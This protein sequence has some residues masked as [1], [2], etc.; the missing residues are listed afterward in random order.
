MP[1]GYYVEADGTVRT[2]KSIEKEIEQT[3]K[4]IQFDNAFREKT[5][6]FNK[7]PYIKKKPKKIKTLISC[8]TVTCPRCSKKI[9]FTEINAH[10]DWHREKI[11]KKI[12]Y[13]IK[14]KSQRAS[15]N[16]QEKNLKPNHAP[17]EHLKENSKK[18]Q[19]QYFGQCP[20][21][22]KLLARKLTFKAHL[23]EEKSLIA[24]VKIKY[25]K[26][27]SQYYKNHEHL[28]QNLTDVH[29]YLLP[30]V[31]R[32]IATALVQWENSEKKETGPLAALESAVSESSL[33]SAVEYRAKNECNDK[34][35]RIQRQFLYEYFK[36][37][38]K[39]FMIKI[40]DIERQWRTSSGLDCDIKKS[41]WK[42]LK[43]FLKKRALVLRI[44]RGY[45]LLILTS[46][47][48][49]INRKSDFFSK[50][51][52]FYKTDK[53]SVTKRASQS[54][55]S[56]NNAYTATI[57]D[58]TGRDTGYANKGD[59]RFRESGRFGSTPLYDDY[60]N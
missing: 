24:S 49:Y 2:A 5:S 14:Q 19:Q 43:L 23:E 45:V 35:L 46:E 36:D 7:T 16:K 28:L 20:Y 13:Q 3:R 4:E 18:K 53:H 58:I 29:G 44:T 34:I 38:E 17:K 6:S 56:S 26:V 27:L 47:P 50:R 21:C 54:K 37:K 31:E 15:Q 9:P 33:N 41:S 1:I 10:L 8:S 40:D 51:Q 59:Y 60:D 57:A 22:N 48:E 25:R 55:S 11:L 30:W 52:F 32:Y 39:G 12:E 42:Y